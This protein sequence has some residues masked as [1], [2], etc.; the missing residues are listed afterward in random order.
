[1]VR[2]GPFVDVFFDGTAVG[3]SG[4][5]ARGFGCWTSDGAAAGE[6]LKIV[7]MRIFRVPKA[8]GFKK[9]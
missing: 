1:M 2:S 5:A 7:Q 9:F 4:L 8:C 3:E 6:M